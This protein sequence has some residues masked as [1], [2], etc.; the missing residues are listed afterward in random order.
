MNYAKEQNIKYFESSSFTGES[1]NEIFAS[2]VE[3][4][5]IILY[6]DIV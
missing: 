5:N 2:L 1:I 6:L 3:G 4:I